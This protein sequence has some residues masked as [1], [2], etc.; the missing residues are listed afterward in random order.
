MDP[1][2]VRHPA[3]STG[4]PPTLERPVQAMVNKQVVVGNIPAP[5][6]GLQPRPALLAQLT[7]AGQAPSAVV[8]TGAW[9][10][11]RPSWPLPTRG[12]GWRAAG[13]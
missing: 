11:A 9:E 2:V 8:L 13:G 12:P 1:T 4:D 5:R 10:W 3:A 6:P 7:Q